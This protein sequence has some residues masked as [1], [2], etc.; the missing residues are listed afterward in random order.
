MVNWSRGGEEIRNFIDVAT[1]TAE[2]IP[3]LATIRW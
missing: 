2:E 3:G 1:S